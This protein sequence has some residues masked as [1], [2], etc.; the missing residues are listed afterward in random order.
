[1]KGEAR[2]RGIAF[3]AALC[4]AAVIVIVLGP[5]WLDWVVVSQSG[6]L[7]ASPVSDIRADYLGGAL[8][9]VFLTLCVFVWGSA[10]KLQGPLL[11]VWVIKALV[12]LG[13]MLLY[14][15]TY[16]VDPDGYFLN[17]ATP[18]FEWQGMQ[19][20]LGTKNTQMLA[21]LHF[22]WISSSYHAS[23]LTF[24]LIG[25]VG[26]Y[27][28]YRAGVILTGRE[29][30]RIFYALALMPSVLFWSTILGK[31]PV[32]FFGIAAYTYGVVAWYTLGKA[33]YILWILVGLTIAVYI[34]MWF[35]PILLIPI[36][37]LGSISDTG[38]AK[39][40]AFVSLGVIG[41]VVSPIVLRNSIGV[42]LFQQGE[43]LEATDTLSRSFERG[44]STQE[45]PELATF[46]DI[47][48]FAPSG[49]FTT[50]FRPLPGEVNNLFGVLAG[51]ENALLVLL[52]IRAVVRTRLRELR[53]PLVVWAIMALLIWA[54]VYSVAS[55]QNLGTLS[56]YKLQIMP[57][58]LGLLLYLGRQRKFD[59]LPQR[60]MPIAA[61][62]SVAMRPGI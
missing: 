34:R 50:L 31:D 17:A 5:R 4:V 2:A 56:R 53:Q 57:L 59:Q 6:P 38:L 48:R 28:T 47:A 43:L 22:H 12:S 42:D 19:I 40:L 61:P 27:L 10:V 3:V 23:R 54:T 1:M 29:D 55:F 52:A 46:G 41:I 37:L 7:V 15:Y 24:G 8:W 21:W 35:A 20:G 44:G 32:T 62:R 39:R 36:G 11:T 16:G 30:R 33:R 49:I 14:D 45:V 18:G 25:L 60:W 58:F 13:A 26:V 51:L 9:A